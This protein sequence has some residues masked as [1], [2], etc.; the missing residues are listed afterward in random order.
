MG[1]VCRRNLDALQLT[2]DERHTAEQIANDLLLRALTLGK[3]YS[4]TDA[5][6]TSTIVAAALMVAFIEGDY[7]ARM[8]QEPH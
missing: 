1:E 7:R 8:Y 5:A 2:E 6:R 4:V 3:K